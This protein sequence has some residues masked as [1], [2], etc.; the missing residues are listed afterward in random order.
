MWIINSIRK[1]NYLILKENGELLIKG[2]KMKKSNTPSIIRNA[3]YHVAD[4]TKGMK[5]EEDVPKI[6]A[7]IE[8][9]V[10]SVI[11]KIQNH[12]GDIGEYAYFTKITKNLNKYQSQPQHVKAAVIEAKNRIDKLPPAIKHTVSVD[13]LIEAGHIQSYVKIGH[14]PKVHP[15]NLASNKIL[16]TTKYLEELQSSLAP[17]IELFEINFADLLGKQKSILEFT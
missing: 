10:R 9:Y 1:K 13:S 12:K 16:D 17:L 11:R 6:K 8:K 7:D 15:T 4:I 2:L 5:T 14:K 3:G